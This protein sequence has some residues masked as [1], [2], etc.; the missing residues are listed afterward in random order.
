MVG[1]PI[2]VV[3]LP[4]GVLPADLAYPD[5][6]RELG[7]EVDARPKELE[8]Y[9]GD[10]IPSDYG[11]DTEIEGIRRHADESGFDRFHLVGYSA[12]GA[13]C[14]AFCA[15]HPER[16]LSLTLNEPAWA[17]NDG[18]S[19]AEL[20]RGRVIEAATQLPP[21]QVMPAFIQAQLRDGVPLPPPPEGPP[22]P[23]MRSRPPALAM[24]PRVWKEHV[25]DEDALRAFTGPVLFTLGGKSH[26]DLYPETAKR[27][28][29]IFP[30]FTL[31]VF[32]DRHH[33]DPP[34]RSEPER[35]ARVLKA[36]WARAEA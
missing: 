17:G 5:L 13:S 1:K 31:E 11:L 20:D 30:N 29:K 14:M 15:A 3:L 28:E 10:E 16:L 32:E 19:D 18:L 23:W 12:G 35:F 34:H 26:P 24:L 2:P 21:A 33:F 4:G 25:L 8:I 22:P 9:A 27:L 7:P 6:I 36:H